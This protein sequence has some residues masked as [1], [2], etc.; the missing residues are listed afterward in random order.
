MCVKLFFLAVLN[1][2]YHLGL[3]DYYQMFADVTSIY[4]LCGFEFWLMQWIYGVSKLLLTLLLLSL[5]PCQS[6][7]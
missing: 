7:T 2:F 3:F 4:L 1:L 5:I 6:Y